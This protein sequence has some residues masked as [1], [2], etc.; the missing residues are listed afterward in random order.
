MRL[1]QSPLSTPS[2]PNSGHGLHSHK[3]IEGPSLGLPQDARSLADHSAL[4][5]DKAA[6]TSPKI[7]APNKAGPSSRENTYMTIPIAKVVGLH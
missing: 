1:A 4:V 2:R 5:D 6:A 3:P 7:K